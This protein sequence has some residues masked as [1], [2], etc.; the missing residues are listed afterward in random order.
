MTIKSLCLNIPPGKRL[1][2]VETKLEMTKFHCTDEFLYVFLKEIFY[3]LRLCVR[4]LN[5]I[6][7]SKFNR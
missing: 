7:F 4:G 2:L 1:I 6:L 3:E 5:T